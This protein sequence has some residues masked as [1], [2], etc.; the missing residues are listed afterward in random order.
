MAAIAKSLEDLRQGHIKGLVGYGCSYECSSMHLGAI[1]KGLHKLSFLSEN[2]PDMPFRD[3]SLVG[4]VEKLRETKPP[5][6]VAT[7]HYDSYNYHYPRKSHECDDK[8]WIYEMNSADLGV[9]ADPITFGSSVGPRG[10]ALGSEL[11]KTMNLQLD[12]F[13]FPTTKET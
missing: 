3:L 9:G 6:W 4:V 1:M 8:P 7:T 12:E 2:S 11:G 5:V 13:L 10:A